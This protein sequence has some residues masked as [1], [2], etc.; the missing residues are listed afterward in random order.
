M[1]ALGVPFIAGTDAR[2]PESVFDN[3]AGALELYSWLGFPT[4][5]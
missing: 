3:F 4:T 1:D 5:E 2:L